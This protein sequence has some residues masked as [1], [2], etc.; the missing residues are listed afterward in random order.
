MDGEVATSIWTRPLNSR[1]PEDREAAQ[2]GLLIERTNQESLP[3]DGTHP[4]ETA[5]RL[6]HGTARER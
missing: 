1:F 4:Y 3:V 6:E 2:V 5:G